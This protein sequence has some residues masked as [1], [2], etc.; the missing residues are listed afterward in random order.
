MY[1]SLKEVYSF[2][3]YSKSFL[4]LILDYKENNTKRYIILIIVAV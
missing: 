4:D 2:T 1:F 3:I